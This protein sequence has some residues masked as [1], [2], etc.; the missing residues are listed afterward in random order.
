MLGFIL[1]KNSKV[2]LIAASFPPGRRFFHLGHKKQQTEISNYGKK[3]AEVVKRILILV[4]ST[5][6]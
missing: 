4:F 3:Q 6:I 2:A 1:R 5:L